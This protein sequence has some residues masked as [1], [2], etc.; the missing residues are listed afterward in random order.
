MADFS[1][2]RT[3]IHAGIWEGVLTRETDQDVQPEVV[4][5]HGQERVRSH[6]LGPDPKQP[7]RWHLRIAIPPDRISDGIQVFLITEA[8]TGAL[9]G[10][11]AIL[12]GEVVEDDVRAEVALLRAE[13]DM[14]KSALRRHLRESE[15]G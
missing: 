8:K 4:V 2:A 1:L 7:G 3:R 5:M 6:S 10:Q 14:V 9:L 15:E 13:L 12:S 11:F